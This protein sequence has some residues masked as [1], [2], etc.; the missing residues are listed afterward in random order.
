L[1]ISLIRLYKQ[2]CNLPNGEM[3]LELYPI[4]L[5]RLPKLNLS[6]QSKQ[7]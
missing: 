3:K 6:D 2:I 4:D 5:T 7:R 1:R